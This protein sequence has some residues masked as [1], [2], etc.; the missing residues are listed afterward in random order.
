MAHLNQKINRHISRELLEIRQTSLI[1]NLTYHEKKAYTILLQLGIPT[2]IQHIIGFYICDF[3]GM[4][5][6]FI[7]E[8]DGSSH[9]TRS[10]Y[11]ARRDQFLLKSGFDTYRISNKEVDKST[12]A[13][14]VAQTP[15]VGTA[16]VQSLLLIVERRCIPDVWNI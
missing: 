16:V 10:T 3:V 14:I 5:R 8:L 11:D 13:A 12:I 4:D 2:Y 1:A 7:L 15:I 9:N 6:N